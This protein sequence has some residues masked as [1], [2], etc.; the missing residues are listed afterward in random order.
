MRKLHLSDVQKKKKKMFANLEYLTTFLFIHTFSHIL[1][2]EL[3]FL[4]G[5][6]ATHHFRKDFT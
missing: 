3:E 5:Y 4:T 6:P 2:K 1:I